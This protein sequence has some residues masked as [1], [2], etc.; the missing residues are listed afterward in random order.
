MKSRTKTK[1]NRASSARMRPSRAST[2]TRA[3]ARNGRE[4]QVDA[5]TLLKNDHAEARKLLEQLASFRESAIERRLATLAK[6]ADAL[7]T[8]MRI[9]E[10][11]FY[12]A[13]EEAG[14]TSDDAVRSCEAWEEH[15]SAKDALRKLE[16]CDPSTTHFRALAKV[17]YDLIDHHAEEEESEMFPRARKL[18]SR[19]RLVSLGAEL[20]AAKTK[21][22]NG[23]DGAWVRRDEGGWAAVT[24]H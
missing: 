24:A 20:E 9:E 21:P 1:K 22:T 7:W 3:G 14:K 23:A 15:A 11:I 5:L 6:V 4:H 19:E 13:F 10:T 8:H 17:V 16:R 2:S 12:P 18:L